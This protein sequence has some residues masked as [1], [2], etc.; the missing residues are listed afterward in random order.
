MLLTLVQTLQPLACTHALE[1]VIFLMTSGALLLVLPDDF[2]IVP[3]FLIQRGIVVLLLWPN[4]GRELASV[5]AVASLTVGVIYA[6]T[7]WDLRRRA[8]QGIGILWRRAWPLSYLPWRTLAAALGVL[9]TFLLVRTYALQALPSLVT[10]AVTWLLVQ[11]GLGLAMSPTPL[12]TALAGLA[13]ADAG[14][15]LYALTR[16]DA[17]IWGLWM[18]C[19]V[20]VGLGAAHLR[21]VGVEAVARS[22]ASS[23]TAGQQAEEVKTESISPVA[24]EALTEES[25]E[26]AT[27]AEPPGSAESDSQTETGVEEGSEAGGAP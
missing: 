5:S 19:D 26:I 7:A 27:P 15:I 4:I 20:L 6:L 18:A 1:L 24:C 10:W 3:V 23:S 9:L 17:V 8:G 2:L 16:P 13:F 22:E 11:F 14:R 12:H 25:G 21:T